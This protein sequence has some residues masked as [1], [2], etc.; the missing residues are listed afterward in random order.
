M[1]QLNQNS[2]KYNTKGATM[3]KGEMS[4]IARQ[5]LRLSSQ[6]A[7]ILQY[8]NDCGAFT[9][10]DFKAVVLKLEEISTELS[11]IVSVLPEKGTFSNDI[12]QNSLVLYANK[13]HET[14]LLEIEHN[15]KLYQKS[16][17]GPYGFF[18]YRK[19][20]KRINSCLNA[21]TLYEK[22]LEEALERE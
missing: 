13:F 10:I 12:L 16:Q 4:F 22:S 18:E 7:S 6:Y 3:T 8:I 9:P 11:T 14:I 2:N 19:D 17:G 20:T 1:I 15:E 21:L 5:C